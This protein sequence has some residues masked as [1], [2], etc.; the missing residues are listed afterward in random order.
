MP[1]YNLITADRERIDPKYLCNSCG[2]LLREA[3]QTACGHFYCRSCLGHLFMWAIKL[4]FMT[5]LA[6]LYLVILLYFSSY[7]LVLSS[8]IKIYCLSFVTVFPFFFR[9]FWLGFLRS[10]LFHCRAGKMLL[11]QQ[12]E[13]T[14]LKNLTDNVDQWLQLN[15]Y[16][17]SLISIKQI[18]V[19]FCPPQ[20]PQPISL[21]LIG[22]IIDCIW[23]GKNKHMRWV[24]KF[25]EVLAS[26]LN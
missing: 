12:R 1:G 23:T 7:S 21:I 15:A 13:V 10:L 8:L 20:R 4:N 16:G 18:L 5:R 19:I 24:R 9:V 25:Q 6:L 26:Y 22:L 14:A 11:S 17:L 3:M 2:L